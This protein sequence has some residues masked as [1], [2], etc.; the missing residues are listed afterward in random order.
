MCVCRPQCVQTM[1]L[2]IDI[3][4]RMVFVRERATEMME[5]HR[6]THVWKFE[7][8]R[9]KTRYGCTDFMK[10]EIRL[11]RYF[12]C[13]PNTLLDDIDNTIA[14][15]MAHAIMG[16]EAGHN[17]EWR[18]K[19]LELGSD[20]ERLCFKAAEGVPGEFK[21]VCPCGLNH[22]TRF[23]WSKRLSLGVCRDCNGHLIK[24]PIT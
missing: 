18:A 22:A 20:G 4:E 13:A 11:S 1:A 6:L 5:K 10:R 16:P 21:V 24:V 2:P 9:A 14:H 12:V 15:E 23:R 3:S 17:E 19:A 7:Y 8:D